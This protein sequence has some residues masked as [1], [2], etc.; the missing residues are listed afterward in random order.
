VSKVPGWLVGTWTVISDEDNT[1][2][3]F[4]EFTTSGTYITH[5]FD[6]SIRVEM[7]FHIHGGDIYITYEIPNKGP[8]A[9][10][11]RPSADKRTLTYTSPRTRNNAVMAK[12]DK[13]CR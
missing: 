5:G 9:L 8:I 7:P 10:V 11:Y 2:P 1:P 12:T 6:C 13:K 3:D 4:T